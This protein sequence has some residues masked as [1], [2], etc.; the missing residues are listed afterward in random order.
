MAAHRLYEVLFDPERLP[1]ELKDK[2]YQKKIIQCLEA[3]LGS[4]NYENNQK[5]IHA[6]QVAREIYFVE[7]GLIRGYY[8]DEDHNEITSVIWDELSIAAESASF[9]QREKMS[10]TM[11]VMAGSHLLSLS[12]EDLMEVYAAFPQAVY[13][14]WCI[15]MKNEIFYQKWNSILRNSFAW[16]RYL[17]LLEVHPSIE[18]KLSKEVIASL[19]NMTPQYLSRLLKNN[20]HP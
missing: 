9:F 10:I 3:K 15:S 5:L 6:G 2:N 17:Q 12:F 20:R 1:K 18:Q 13:F 19:L 16:S 4:F 8:I 7:K 11:E 14:T